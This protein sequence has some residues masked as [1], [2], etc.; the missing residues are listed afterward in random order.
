M[1]EFRMRGPR[2]NKKSPTLSLDPH[3]SHKPGC[4]D[5]TSHRS[6]SLAA[7]ATAITSV[8]TATAI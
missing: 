7:A 5:D 4:I 8:S 3:A 1:F 6:C 2:M